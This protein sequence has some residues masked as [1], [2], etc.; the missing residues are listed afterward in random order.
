MTKF[1]EGRNDKTTAEIDDHDQGYRRQWRDR[2]AYV[3]GSML[4]DMQK[5]VKKSKVDVS[6]VNRRIESLTEYTITNDDGS[7]RADLIWCGAFVELV[8][9]GTW[10]RTGNMERD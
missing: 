5:Q 1:Q 8:C 2:E 3:K 4:A 9:D 10:A 6:F 7:T